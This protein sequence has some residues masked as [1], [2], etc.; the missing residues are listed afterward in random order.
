MSCGVKKIGVC[1]LWRAVV[2]ALQ[3]SCCLVERHVEMHLPGLAEKRIMRV[4]VLACLLRGVPSHLHSF[5]CQRGITAAHTG[6]RICMCLEQFHP[7]HKCRERRAP[8]ET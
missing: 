3:R 8:Q 2:G 5:C 7:S 4:E 6:S 1:S